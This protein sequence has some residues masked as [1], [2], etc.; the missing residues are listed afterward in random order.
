MIKY[1]LLPFVILPLSVA[2]ADTKFDEISVGGIVQNR[3]II[4]A[5]HGIPIPP[6]EWINT[7]KSAEVEQFSSPGGSVKKPKHTFTFINKNVADSPLF[8]LIVTFFPEVPD[9]TWGKPKCESSSGSIVE[10]FDSKSDPT[11]YLCAQIWSESKFKERVSNA[12]KSDNPYVRLNL[13]SLKNYLDKVPDDVFSASIQGGKDHGATLNYTF[14]L[15]R[16]ADP[17]K[18]PSYMAY[19]KS[20]AHDAGLTIL[21]TLNN[22]EA[23]FEA[24]RI[25]KPAIGTAEATT[26]GATIPYLDKV[27]L[28]VGQATVIHGARG[29]QCGQQAPDWEQIAATLPPSVTG[30]FSDGGLGV[31]FSQRCGGDTP[32]R[33]IRFTATKPGSEQLRLFGDPVRIEVSSGENEGTSTESNSIPFRDKVSLAVG[34]TTIIHGARGNRCGDPA[35]DWVRIAP[36][37]PSPKTGKLSDG[38]V[39]VRSSQNCGGDT[40]ARAI[41]FT[42]TVPG[43]EQIR[44]FGNPIDIEVK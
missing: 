13:S 44:V 37:L 31:R 7:G 14:F 2:R 24:A 25:Y 22:K 10:K 40:P 35:P 28:G 12:E 32:A 26:S 15:A 6:G 33:A 19:I 30:K 34:E 11:L 27:S 3:I 43:S 21:D 16:V 42:A 1:F 18:D 4:D 29:S 39:G 36:T 23:A 5:N 17:Y 41:R 38:G 9:T 20:G 8:A